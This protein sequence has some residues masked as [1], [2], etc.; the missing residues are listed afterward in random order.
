MNLHLFLTE[1][2]SAAQLADA[3][4][5]S[6]AQ[7]SQWRTGYRIPDPRSC[8]AIEQATEGHVRRWDLRPVDWGA[9]W[10]ELIGTEG[11]PKWPRETA[12]AA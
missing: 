9:I 12:E 2:F 11:S 5:V 4:G 10:P 1:R 8:V 3:L 6:A 7:I